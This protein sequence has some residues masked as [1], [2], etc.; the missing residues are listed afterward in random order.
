MTE[1]GERT[2]EAVWAVIFPFVTSGAGSSLVGNQAGPYRETG[3]PVIIRSEAV[4]QRS[5][6]H[7]SVRIAISLQH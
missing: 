6:D 7:C 2:F 5:V 3:R 1:A 4:R